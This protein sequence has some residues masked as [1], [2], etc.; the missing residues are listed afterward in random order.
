MIKKGLIGLVLFFC[1][2][3]F[4]PAGLVLFIGIFFFVYFLLGIYEMYSSY[5]FQKKLKNEPVDESNS[6][7]TDYDDDSD[8]LTSKYFDAM[9]NPSSFE[10]YKASSSTLRDDWLIFKDIILNIISLI[11]MKSEEI[12]SSS[13]FMSE[14]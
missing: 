14:N 8:S 13:F 6:V 12:H 10:Y 9:Y 3:K 7:Y 2:L 5:R 11:K 4:L 1:I